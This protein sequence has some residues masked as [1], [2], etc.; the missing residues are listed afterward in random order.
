VSVAVTARTEAEIQRTAADCVKAKAKAVAVRAAISDGE[1][2][3]QAY[4]GVTQALG[5]PDI[6]VNSAGLARSAPFLKTDEGLLDLHWKANVLS[7]FFPTLAALPAMVER[8]W[9]RI[10]TIASVSGKVGAPYIAAY[11]AS[12]HAALGLTRS[13]AAEFA[14]KGVTSNAVCPGYVDTG[15]TEENI[16]IIAEKTGM[17]IAQAEQRLKEMSPQKRLTEPEEVAATVLFL[18]SELAGNI[19]GQAITMDG[20]ALQW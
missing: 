11:A 13:V 18:C 15:M 19:N 7:V 14:A 9:G 2:A 3:L 6:L 4:R 16:R 5:A 20:G 10:V 12:K 17:T 8:G 1:Q